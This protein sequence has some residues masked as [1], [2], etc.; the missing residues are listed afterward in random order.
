MPRLRSDRGPV[1]MVA[2]SDGRLEGFDPQRLQRC[3]MCGLPGCVPD[4]R[5]LCACDAVGEFANGSASLIDY[6]PPYYVPK[7]LRNLFSTFWTLHR[8]FALLDSRRAALTVR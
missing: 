7:D 4:G 6:E 8:L 2:Q 3:L 1:M 5:L